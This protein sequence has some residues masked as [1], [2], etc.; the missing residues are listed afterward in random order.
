MNETINDPDYFDFEIFD[1][2]LE[3]LESTYN[4]IQKNLIREIMLK[5]NVNIVDSGN[6]IIRI[7]KSNDRNNSESSKAAQIQGFCYFDAFKNCVGMNSEL[8]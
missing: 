2:D 8:F 3:E 7:N 4:F 6:Q 5:F 1:P